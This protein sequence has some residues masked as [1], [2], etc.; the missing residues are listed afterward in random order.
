VEQDQFLERNESLSTGD[1]VGLL[2]MAHGE[3]RK[4]A[5]NAAAMRLVSDLRIRRVAGQVEIGF[6]RSAPTIA[7]ALRGLAGAEIH[8][9]PLFMSDGYFARAGRD[10]LRQAL[11]AGRCD[12]RLTLFPPL[13]LDPALADAIAVRAVTAARTAGCKAGDAELVLV[14]HGSSGDPASQAA[15]EALAQRVRRLGVFGTTRT[16]FLEQPPFLC[17]VLSSRRGP[18]VVVGLFAAEGRHGHVDLRR[19]IAAPARPEILFAGNVGAW[20]E[21]G[22]I[23]AARCAGGAKPSATKRF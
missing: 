21:I 1:D 10:E 11:R 18:T 17:E 23:I 14:A 2:L 15:A 8:V 7:Q 19:S 22:D 4:G 16:V 13:G 12:R 3:R 6:L 9:F 5:G 20:P